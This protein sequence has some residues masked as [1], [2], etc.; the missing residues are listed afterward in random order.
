MFIGN[1]YEKHM[2]LIIPC[3][4]IYIVTEIRVTLFEDLFQ[5]QKSI[6]GLA[7]FSLN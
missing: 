1:N 2:H 7:G 3:Q 4:K 5:P 6:C